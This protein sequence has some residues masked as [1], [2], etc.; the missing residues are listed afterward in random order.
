MTFASIIGQQDIK[1]RLGHA[2]SGNPG[3]AFLFLG[4]RGTGRSHIAWRFAAALLCQQPD[5]NGACGQCRS[6]RYMQ[7][8][9]HPDYR[10]LRAREKE[11]LIPVEL[12]RRSVSA[13]VYLRSQISQRKV[14][15]IALDDLNEQGQNALLKSLEEPPPFVVFLLTASAADRL[16]PTLLSRAVVM[17]IGRYTPAEIMEILHERQ[18]DKQESAAFFSRFSHGVPGVAIEL[19]ESDWFHELR[20]DTFR[21]FEQLSRESRASLL[22]TGFA[23]LDQNRPV[24]DDILQILGSMIRDL[25][26]LAGRFTA[27][28]LINEDYA[29]LLR[30]AADQLSNNK[31]R[32]W[33]ER[34]STAYQAIISARRALSL[35]GSFEVLACNLILALRKELIYA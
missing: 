8:G 29:D 31:E 25:M 30:K 6:C 21:F 27:S 4:A 13:D 23:F 17:Q 10:V 26:M 7:Q 22:T 20:T 33:R 2:L 5:T 11:K 14:Y 28:Q 12:V 35:N 18:L 34:L 24:L 32:D 3:H 15:L 1:H 16:L 19:A 9:V